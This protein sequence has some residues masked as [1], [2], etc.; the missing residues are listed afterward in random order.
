MK[1]HM[2]LDR[3]QKGDILEIILRDSSRRKIGSWVINVNDK[4][5]ARQVLK[6]LKLQ[7][8][9]DFSL[10]LKEEKDLDWIP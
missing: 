3:K 2:W 6:T 5:R 1:Q 4:K 8:G 10:D 7:Y 9:I